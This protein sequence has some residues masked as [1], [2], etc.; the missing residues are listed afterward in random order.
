MVGKFGREMASLDSEMKAHAFNTI[1]VATMNDPL[2]E[3]KPDVALVDLSDSFGRSGRGSRAEVDRVKEAYSVPVIVFI[4]KDDVPGYEPLPAADDFISVPYSF[5]EV[6]ARI[7]Q[8]LW[9][10]R[11][12]KTDNLLK[13]GD[14][15]IDL[16]SYKV[17]LA[18]K[19]LDLT[20]K[21]YELLRFLAS[22][23]D[24]VFSREALLNQ[25]WGYD[26]YGGDRTVDVH[27][28]RLRSKIE[29]ASHSFIETVWNVGYRFKV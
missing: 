24:K 3:G 19:L 6:D 8:A 4:R 11:N 13:R 21:E 27:I 29:D 22:K 7:R 20:F 17:Y 25:V 16:S 15:V 1:R 26:Y 5:P 2:P 12:L 23:P 18:G 14:L 10:T 28:R 9:Q